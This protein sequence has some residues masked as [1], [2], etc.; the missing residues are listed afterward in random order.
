MHLGGENWDVVAIGALMLDEQRYSQDSESRTIA[1]DADIRAR[2]PLPA[3]RV[4]APRWRRNATI[5]CRE[6]V[7]AEGLDDTGPC[8]GGL[9]GATTGSVHATHHSRVEA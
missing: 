1:G 8:P 3:S 5:T 7:S 2:V 6:V 4:H 9:D